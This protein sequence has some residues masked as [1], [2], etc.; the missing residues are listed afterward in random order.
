MDPNRYIEAIRTHGYRLADGAEAAGLDAVVPSCPGW[1][2][3]DLVG[4]ADTVC[5]FWAA[6][7]SG[8]LA[9]PA[10]FVPRPDVPPAGVLDG[11]RAEVDALAGGL[12]PLDPAQPC[13]TW[14][15][16]HTVGFVQRRLAHELAVHGW[17][18]TAARGQ[19]IPIEAD[20]AVD[21]V[22]EYLDVFVPTNAA[23]ADGA[24]L[25]G[26]LHA[27][28]ADGEWV[29]ATGD[30]AWRVERAHAKGD[31]AIRGTASDLVAL[32]WGRRSID[33][34]QFEV[35]GDAAS[36]AGFLARLSLG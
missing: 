24:A 29:V 31:V 10:D 23:H 35:F 9:D 13:W 20:L 1:T 34:G 25:S 16:D 5:Q 2:V 33:G 7:A 32:L 4:H 17:D 18:A 21:G 14:T 8:A 6:I 12:A 36:V 3:A 19:G 11:F 22:D 30:G 15:D 26:H 28:D 27:T